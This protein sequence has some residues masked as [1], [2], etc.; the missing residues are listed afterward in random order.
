LSNL[1]ISH[2]ITAE[3]FVPSPWLR[4]PHIMTIAQALIPRGL[5]MRWQRVE[6]LLLQVTP[7]TSL[8]A[9]GHFLENHEKRPTMIL[10]HGLEGSSESFYILGMAEKALAAGINVIRLNIRNCGGTLHLTPTLYNAGLSSDV[11][12]VID[13]LVSEKKLSD[14]FL[15]GYSLG[16]NLVVK[17]T[18][19]LGLRTKWVSGTCAIAPA[20][21]LPTCIDAMEKGFNR[22]YEL[23]FL[24]SLKRKMVL[25][26]KLFPD[27][28]D[29][30]GLKNIRTLR[31][32]DDTYTAPDGGYKNVAHYYETASSKPL[33]KSITTPTL[34]IT[35]QDD[36]LVPYESFIDLD[37]DS[38]RVVAPKHGGHAAFLQDMNKGIEVASDPFWL[39]NHIT[40]F[41]LAHSKK[42]KGEE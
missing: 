8:V 7:D 40:A 20:L 41:C 4:N 16:G 23:L 2:R 27:K 29:L 12:R 36:P 26:K 30:S 10:V 38:V 32:F 21:D 15:V 24:T 19:E 31:T 37:T 6:K 1:P 35:A 39:D 33:V 18:A 28:F 25:K 5:G 17:A 9:Y 34:I 22:F 3:D 11:L 13:L 42:L 14:L